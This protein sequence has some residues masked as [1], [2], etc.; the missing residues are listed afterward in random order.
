MQ[1][2]NEHSETVLPYSTDDP[3]LIQK[4]ESFWQEMDEGKEINVS[5]KIECLQNSCPGAAINHQSTNDKVAQ[6]SNIYT[7]E[8]NGI[9]PEFQ[10]P[11]ESHLSNK[12]NTSGGTFKSGQV[13]QKVIVIGVLL[14]HS[15]YILF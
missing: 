10:I 9:S 13:C 1:E 12:K 8:R 11:H 3:E 14:P 7:S 5:P 2:G 4:S 15:V 6:A